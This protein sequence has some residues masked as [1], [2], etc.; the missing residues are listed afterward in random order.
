LLAG[1]TTIMFEGIPTWP[2]PAV[3]GKW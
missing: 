1:A 2:M 3:S